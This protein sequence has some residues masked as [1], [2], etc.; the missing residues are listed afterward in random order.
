MYIN[1]YIQGHL[2]VLGFGLTGILI[3][4]TTANTWEIGISRLAIATIIFLIIFH[5][6]KIKLT[7]TPKKIL[8]GAS[9]GIVFATHWTL[10]F[11]AFNYA[12]VA[13]VTFAEM[14]YSFFFIILGVI[15]CKESRKTVDVFPLFMGLIGAIILLPELN[16]ENTETIGFFLATFSG[17]LF[18]IVGILQKKFHNK[19]SENERPFFQYFFALLFF[20]MFFPKTHW[21][22]TTKDWGI[23]CVLG[24]VGTAIAH[25]FWANANAKL[26]TKINSLLYLMIP[27]YASVGAFF[28]LNE[29]ITSKIL[30][31]GMFI[32]I[33]IFRLQKQDS[34]TL[35]ST[36]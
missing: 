9:I 14:L 23:L 1:P 30:L 36:S 7:W 26:S 16:L 12:S 3:K 28:F 6:K 11:F 34:S 32:L 5:F 27:I 35:T 24:I 29:E 17:F 15:F 21:E 8:M 10:Y 19:L 33:G 13:T 20:L 25:T 31:G 22:F 18:A 2:A 4:S